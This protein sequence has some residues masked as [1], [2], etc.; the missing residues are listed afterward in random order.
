MTCLTT[1][2]ILCLFKA[3][4]GDQQSIHMLAESLHPSSTKLVTLT[5]RG[6]K[7]MD[8]PLGTYTTLTLL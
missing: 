7:Q 8:S 3:S 4:L 5:A 6:E 2:L 1:P